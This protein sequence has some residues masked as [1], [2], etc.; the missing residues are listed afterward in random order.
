[1]LFKATARR[2][3]T[4]GGTTESDTDP[5][6]QWWMCTELD[7]SLIRCWWECKVA[8]HPENSLSVSSKVKYTTAI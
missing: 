3:H 5:D 6:N 8:N 1:M 7:L 2:H 4:H